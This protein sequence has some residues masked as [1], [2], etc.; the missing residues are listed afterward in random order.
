M[1]NLRK[2]SGK[3]LAILLLMAFLCSCAQT[4]AD[5]PQ[6]TAADAAPAEAFIPD[7]ENNVTVDLIEAD[8]IELDTE[9]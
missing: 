9:V 3:T 1:N 5:S 6:G 7:A 4:S 2:R 8:N